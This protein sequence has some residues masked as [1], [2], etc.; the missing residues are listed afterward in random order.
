M[1]RIVAERAWVFI[2]GVFCPEGARTM[3]KLLEISEE[4]RYYVG[5]ENGMDGW[6]WGLMGGGSLRDNVGS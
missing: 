3:F 1:G 4:A 6:I 2:G 5:G